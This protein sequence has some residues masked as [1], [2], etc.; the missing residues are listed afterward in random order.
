MIEVYEDGAEIN[1]DEQAL[2]VQAATAALKSE[3]AKG[4]LTVVVASEQRIH[5]L[6]LE[7]RSIDRVTDVLTFPAWDGKPMDGYLGDIMICKKRAQ[8]QAEQYGHSFDRE[9]TFLTLHGV[10]HLLGYD[11]M[12]PSDEGVMLDKQRKLLEGLGQSR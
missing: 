4:D 1:A 6:N 3:N 5:Q 2:I 10:L 12:T 9:L 11:H 7:F 8:E